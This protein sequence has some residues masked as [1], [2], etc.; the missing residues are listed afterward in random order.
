MRMRHVGP[1]AAEH[2]TQVPDGARVE[3]QRPRHLVH[4]DAL[5]GHSS[6]QLAAPLC[7]EADVNARVAG[8]LPTQETDLILAAPPLAAGIDLQQADRGQA[9]WPT[10]LSTWRSSARVKVR[11][12]ES[13]EERQRVAPHRIA[14]G[15]DDSLGHR[16]M[17]AREVLVHL[18]SAELRHPQIAD[19]SVE[20]MAQRPLEGIGPIIGELDVVAPAL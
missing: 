5:G 1:E 19:D 18:P 4:Q 17:L 15:K 6:G 8:Q 3:A 2:A 11:T 9:R 13:L 14:G 7:D 20:R 12:A 10:A 16:G